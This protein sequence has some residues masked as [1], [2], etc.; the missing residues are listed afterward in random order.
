MSDKAVRN[1]W[2][3]RQTCFEMLKDRK[4]AVA[5]EE[6]GEDF[7]AFAARFAERAHNRA[8]MS[9]VGTSKLDSNDRVL[10]YFADEAGKVGVKPIKTLVDQLDERALRAAVFVALQPLTTF[11]KNAIAEY[12]SNYKIDFFLESELLFNITK[13]CYVPTHV[14]LT[15]QEKEVLLDSYKIKDVMLPRISQH[16]AVA[17]YLGLVRGDVVK[18]IRASESAGRYVTYRLCF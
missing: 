11:A 12:S 14:K 13:H 2:R 5:E 15:E 7:D 6:T 1:L 17:R 18:I 8:A 9:F 4:Y 3:C 16:D 10:V